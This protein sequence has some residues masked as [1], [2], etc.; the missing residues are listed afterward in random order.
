MCSPPRCL[1]DQLL[2]KVD[3]GILQ[4]FLKSCFWTN[5]NNDKCT[6]C[7]KINL[8]RCC[9]CE[10]QM[11]KRIQDNRFWLFSSI[12]HHWLP[13]IFGF[14]SKHFSVA[15]LYLTAQEIHYAP[16]VCKN[17]AVIYVHFTIQQLVA[18]L[19]SSTQYIQVFHRFFFQLRKVILLL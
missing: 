15:F 4:I 10:I 16:T 14:C 13:V 5:V 2:T 12:L 11:Y 6:Q 3:S 1:E 17:L 8:P 19:R 7:V 9:N 18:P